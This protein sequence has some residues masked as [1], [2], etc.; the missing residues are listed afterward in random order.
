MRVVIFNRFTV[1]PF[2]FSSMDQEK[3]LKIS[4]RKI[5][6]GKHVSHISIIDGASRFLE[7]NGFAP[8][9]S[10]R[11][12]IRQ[13]LIVILPESMVGEMAAVISGIESKT[14]SRKVEGAVFE[15][16]SEIQFSTIKVENAFKIPKVKPEPG[17]QFSDFK[18]VGASHPAFSISSGAGLDRVPER[19]QE[20]IA[21]KDLGSLPMKTAEGRYADDLDKYHVQID[22]I[23]KGKRPD[24][25][26]LSLILRRVYMIRC[27]TLNA[28]VRRKADDILV[29]AN[30]YVSNLPKGVPDDRSK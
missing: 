10:V 21:G 29:V 1:T 20:L 5:G 17:S 18:R 19:V 28:G 23:R 12:A 3:N 7:K 11:V 4:R 25:A 6:D 24:L 30:H 13:G 8:G 15:D 16:L 27:K 26:S 22:Y 9:D 14:K 2:F